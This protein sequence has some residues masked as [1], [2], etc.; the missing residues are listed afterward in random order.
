MKRATTCVLFALFLLFSASFEFAQTVA[1]TARLSDAEQRTIIMTF[2]NNAM[3][4]LASPKTTAGQPKPPE[5]YVADRAMANL[6]RALF[7]FD[8]KY[9]DPWHK[10]EAVGLDVI[11]LRI[12]KAAVETPNRTVLDVMGELVDSCYATYYTDI[13]KS[14]QQKARFAEKTDDRQ[15]I[16]FRMQIELYDAKK[17]NERLIA[18]LEQR[19]KEIQAKYK[20]MY[21]DAIIL[22]D[23]RRVQPDH[24]GELNGDFTVIT[25]EMP[26]DAD[27]EVQV[28]G[29]YKK[30]AQRI[31]ACMTNR[32]IS[33]G[34][35][36]REA[37]CK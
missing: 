24:S 37:G 6:V 36:A 26:N 30:E 5:Q 2:A 9:A 17:V 23:G 19:D 25:A 3:V 22:S 13:Q 27:H 7:T 28:Q 18:E 29:A 14:E 11:P 12:K 21:D 33:T 34:V 31:Y 20:Q 16:E 32:Q 35:K 1:D 10:T 8:A 15:V 4:N